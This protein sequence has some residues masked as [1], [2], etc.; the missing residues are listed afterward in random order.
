MVRA[1]TKEIQNKR[2]PLPGVVRKGNIP[3]AINLKDVA[4]RR[5]AI[6]WYSGIFPKK[7][8]LKGMRSKDVQQLRN[9][10]AKDN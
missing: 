3:P 1:R 7:K 6:Y 10:F 8:V 9:H 2:R 4:I 5:K